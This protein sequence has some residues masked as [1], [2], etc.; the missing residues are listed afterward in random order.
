MVKKHTY[1]VAL[2]QVPE[3]REHIKMT[4]TFLS[5]FILAVEIKNFPVMGIEKLVTKAQAQELHE[6]IKDAANEP[7]NL[8]TEDIHTIY[9][10]H[11]IANKILVSEYD[12][13]IVNEILKR[14]REDSHLKTFQAF[15]Q[16][17]ITCNNHMIK[18]IEIKMPD[19]DGL[20]ELKEKLTMLNI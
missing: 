2:P 20:A 14:V 7:M 19:L 9:A 16:Y 6:R 12:E 4:L 18:D 13:I 5:A 8:S 15:R 11:Y 10:A 17:C 1:S 3:F